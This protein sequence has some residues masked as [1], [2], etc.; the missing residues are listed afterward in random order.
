MT[1][2]T[3]PTGKGS[4]PNPAALHPW[5]NCLWNRRNEQSRL[6]RIM[7]ETTKMKATSC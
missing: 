1:P 6:K 5:R 4:K 3:K 2:R 7:E